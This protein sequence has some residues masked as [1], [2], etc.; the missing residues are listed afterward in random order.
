MLKA[1]PFGKSN[2]HLSQDERDYLNRLIAQP[3]FSGQVAAVLLQL[4]AKV[5]QTTEVEA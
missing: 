1:K 2:P 4:E 3:C 5:Q